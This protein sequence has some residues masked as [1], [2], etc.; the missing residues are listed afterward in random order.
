MKSVDRL[1]AEHNIIERGLNV[2]EKAVTR[3]ESS[4]PIPEEFPRW[5]PDFFLL[6]EN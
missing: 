5:A 4:Q 2:L 1:V 6:T 3:I